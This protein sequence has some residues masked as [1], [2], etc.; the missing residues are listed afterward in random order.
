MN[1]GAI[2]PELIDS[3][4][5]GHE[6]GSFT[7]ASAARQGWFERAD[8]GTLFLDEIGELPPA[9]QVRMLRVLQDGSFERVGGNK[10]ITVDVR[11]V[12]ATNADLP[13]LIAKGKFRDDLWYRINVFPIHLPSLRQRPDDIPA[14][15][16]H[17]A[18]RAGKRLGGRPLVPTSRD[19]ELLSAYSWPGNVHEL[20]AVIERAAILGSGRRLEI[21]KALGTPAARRADDAFRDRSRAAAFESPIAGRPP[22]GVA[23]SGD[24]TTH[25]EH[26]RRDVRTRRGTIWCRATTGNQSAHTAIADAETRHRLDAVSDRLGRQGV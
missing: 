17:F 9:A 12:A 26:A 22:G 5:F 2:P 15:A 4:L 18:A 11:L 14:F 10:P 24:E 20:A 8:G 21:A 25:R 7:G 19:V 16:A 6:R 23:R 3:E 1:C 13:D